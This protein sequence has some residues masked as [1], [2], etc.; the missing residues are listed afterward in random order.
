MLGDAELQGTCHCG[1]VRLTLPSRPQKAI[2]CNCSLCR[3]VGAVWAYYEFGA[4]TIHGHPEN[5]DS[6]VQGCTRFNG[7][8]GARD[9]AEECLDLVAPEGQRPDTFS[10]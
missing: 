10:R 3:R 6:Y 8:D 4:V 2:R 9:T 7:E 1:A 5:T